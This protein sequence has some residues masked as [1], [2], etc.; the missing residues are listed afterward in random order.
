M[1]RVKLISIGD[2]ILIGQIV[3]TNASSICSKLFSIGILADKVITIAD[4]EE[5]LL[6]E[7]EDSVNNYDVTIITGGLG[8]THDDLTKP[9]L[10]KY[11]NDELISDEK[12]LIHIKDFFAKRN[13]KMPDANF[14]QALVP[15]NSRIIWNANGTAPG[16]WIE[17]NDKV[18]IAMPGVPYEMNAMMD[19]D[20]LRLLSEKFSGKINNNLKSKTILTTG[21]GESVLAEMIGDVGS[22]IGDCKLAFLPSPYGVR[23]RIDS[24]GAS[25]KESNDKLLTIETRLKN[26]IGK[27]IFGENSE[28]L[29]KIVGDLLKKKNLSLSVA[30]SCTGGLIS[31]RLTDVSGSSEYFKGGI[32][33]YSNDSKVNLLSV[34]KST[35]EKSGAVSEE[36]AIEMALNVKTKFQSDIGISTTGIAGPTG[37]TPDKP[38]GLVWIGYSDIENTYAGKYLFGDNR[39]IVKIRASQMALEIIRQKLI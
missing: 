30:E 31:S 1:L 24:N 23:L 17:K 29:E 18:I 13:V 8:P 9:V 21:I 3:N 5:P 34:N 36:T 12:V 2:E 15:R 35:I 32:C 10:T 25:E 16:I 14:E 26:K 38:V 37:G 27:Y 39:N 19:N 4:A 11:F 6:K 33:T 28:I 20:V 7:L 22:F